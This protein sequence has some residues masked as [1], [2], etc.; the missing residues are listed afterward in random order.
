MLTYKYAVATAVLALGLL[1]Q[2]PA[3]AKRKLVKDAR[4]AK[5]IQVKGFGALDEA[6]RSDTSNCT[7]S[8]EADG[9][10]GPFVQYR[11][12][13]ETTRYKNNPSHRSTL[14]VLSLEYSRTATSIGGTEVTSDLGEG[15]ERFTKANLLLAGSLVQRQAHLQKDSQRECGTVPNPIISNY[16]CSYIEYVTILFAPE[17]IDAFVAEAARNPLGFF[18][19]KLTSERNSEKIVQ[20]PLNE[21]RLLIEAETKAAAALFPPG[22]S[23]E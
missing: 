8:A 20:I 16:T 10:A 9:D 21:L 3:L 6:I 15:P 12:W 23:R 5:C 17:E 18:D 7:R 19:I 13:F 1:A 4:Y 14:L 11:S 22:E 2:Q